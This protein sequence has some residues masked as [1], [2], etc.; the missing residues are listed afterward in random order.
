MQKIIL[1][2]KSPR[3]A[4]LL[5]NLGI[6]FRIVP[7]EVNERVV[8]GL[9]LS[10]SEFVLEVASRKAKAVASRYP[11]AIVLAADTV[12]CFDDMIL[13]KPVDRED[14]RRMLQLLSGNVH[15][16]STGVVLRQDAAEKTLY[17]VVTTRV[18]FR[19]L[20]PVEIEGYLATGEPF[21]KAGGYGIQGYGALLVERIE[22][23]YFNVVGLPLAKVGEMLKGFG[24][25]LLCPC[26][27]TI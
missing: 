27:N 16:V 15:E 5:K 14:A 17:E 4:E 24:V 9:N 21:D 13:G 12:V 1:A 10:S 22:G 11:H 19:R 25:E 20:T 3:R 26:P 18:F 7:S 2:S 23:C 6:P 8:A